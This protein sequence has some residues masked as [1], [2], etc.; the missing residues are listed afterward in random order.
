M[1]FVQ[2]SRDNFGSPDELQSALRTVRPAPV[3]HVVSGGDHSL[4]LARRDSNVQTAVYDDA[5]RTIGEWMA[6]VVRETEKVPR[7]V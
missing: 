7:R 5:R 4:R 6:S 1:L 2:G 3:I